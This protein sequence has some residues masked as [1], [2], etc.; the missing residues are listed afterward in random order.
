MFLIIK[1]L[2]LKGSKKKIKE[3]DRQNKHEENK[4]VEVNPYVSGIIA[5]GTSPENKAG[6]RVESLTEYS[7]SWRESKAGWGG[8]SGM[9]WKTVLGITG[10]YSPKCLFSNLN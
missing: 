2:N 10:L 3:E 5:P 8:G 4:V 7:Q 9:R 1:I 6:Y